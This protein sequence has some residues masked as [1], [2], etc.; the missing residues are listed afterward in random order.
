VRSKAAL[1]ILVL[2]AC[3]GASGAF[4]SSASA[5]DLV[6]TSFDSGAGRFSIEMLGNPI[7]TEKDEPTPIGPVR[8]NLFSVECG[9]IVLDAEYS[10]LPNIAALFGGRSRIY[11]EIVDEF[12]K[13][14]HAT[15]VTID[16]FVLDAYHG[17]ILTYETPSRMGKLW[18]LLISRRLYVLHASVP[19][20][21]RDPS[22]IDYYFSTFKPT[23]KSLQEAH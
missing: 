18:M 22:V 12:L 21:Y 9:P 5:N 7:C 11:R 15:E 1:Q 2:V 17:R 3:F 13:R 6:W 20:D 16:P 10:I 8:E 23:Y 4:F 14:T 19:K